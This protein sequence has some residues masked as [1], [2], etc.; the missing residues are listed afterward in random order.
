MSNVSIFTR[1]V[2]KE[3]I[4]NP[5]FYFKTHTF[6]LKQYA[7]QLGINISNIS[8]NGKQKRKIFDRIKKAL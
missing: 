8:T 5:E 6:T 1:K 7:K 3:A 2:L 4:C